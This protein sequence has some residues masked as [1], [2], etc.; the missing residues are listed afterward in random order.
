L[1]VSSIHCI[2]TRLPVK[3]WKIRPKA[4]NPHG[5]AKNVDEGDRTVVKKR[6]SSAPMLQNIGTAKMPS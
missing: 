2:R 3:N 5:K 1:V 6:K 4:V